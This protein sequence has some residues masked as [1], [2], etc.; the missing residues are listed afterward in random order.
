M[1]TFH[2][3]S[4]A[5]WFTT[6]TQ[7]YHSF[8]PITDKKPIYFLSIKPNNAT[9]KTPLLTI[10]AVKLDFVFARKLVLF[11]QIGLQCQSL[12]IF[13][14]IVM[15]SISFYFVNRFNQIS[16]FHAV[17]RKCGQLRCIRN[18]ILILWKL[19]IFLSNTFMIWYR[20]FYLFPYS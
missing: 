5:S 19:K 9:N 1:F 14:T 16:E 17:R 12:I 8:S 13:G 11:S 18:K 6:K 3:A 15:R 20:L 10:E 2:R 4:I 7:S